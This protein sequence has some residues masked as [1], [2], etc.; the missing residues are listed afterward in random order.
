MNDLSFLRLEPN[1]NDAK[2]TRANQ[3]SDIFFYGQVTLSPYKTYVQE[4]NTKD[5]IAFNGN[6]AVFVVDCDGKELK[7]ITNNVAIQEVIINGTPQIR[8]EIVNIGTD[9]YAKTV[10]FKFVHTVSDYVWYSNPINITDNYSELITRFDYKNATDV[11]MKSIRLKCYFDV[12]DSESVSGEY[13]TYVGNKVTSRLIN[14]ELEKYIFQ[15]V[16]NFTFRRLNYLLSRDIVYINGN[17]VTNKQTLGSK[18]TLGSSNVFNLDFKVPVDYNE[19]YTAGFQIFTPIQLISLIPI[20]SYTAQVPV[21]T[22]RVYID[23][24]SDSYN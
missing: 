8:F 14:T 3:V 16:D 10:F 7:E 13:T 15:K 20:G 24:Y 6:Y 23:S 17:K 1:F 4:T 11:L 18:E 5:G 12:N 21:I 9:F 22:T 19:I 2:N